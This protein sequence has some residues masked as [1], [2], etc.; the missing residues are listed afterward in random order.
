MKH[1][2]SKFFRQ[3][4]AAKLFALDIMPCGSRL[5]CNPPP[6]NTDADYL[7]FC[8]KE[9]Y[10]DFSVWLCENE[11]VCDGS[12]DNMPEDEKFISWKQGPENLIISCS[13][14]FIIR[15]QAATAV[16]KRLN[17]LNKDDRKMV[18]QAVLYGKATKPK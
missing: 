4:E 3:D 1:D 13:N 15:H 18:F 9:M 6:E 14:L 11:W 8:D 16:C 17:L 7:I 10:S 5:T 2:K 12:Y